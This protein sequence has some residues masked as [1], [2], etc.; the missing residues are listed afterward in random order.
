MKFVINKEFV[1]EIIKNHILIDNGIDNDEVREI[2]FAEDKSS[3][4]VDVIL[5]KEFNK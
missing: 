2:V 4:I 3:Y 1:E 5:D